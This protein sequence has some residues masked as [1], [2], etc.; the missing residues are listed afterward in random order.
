MAN[1]IQILVKINDLGRKD[2][3]HFKKFMYNS[4]PM[5]HMNQANEQ[6]VDIVSRDIN[7]D[8]IVDYCAT[9]ETDITTIYYDIAMG[10]AHKIEVKYGIVASIKSM[11]F[12]MDAECAIFEDSKDKEDGFFELLKDT[13]DN[14]CVDD[15][16]VIKVGDSIWINTLLCNDCDLVEWYFENQSRELKV[17]HIDYKSANLYVDGCEYGININEVAKARI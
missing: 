11:T 10:Y 9:N 7:M 6:R 1:A 4:I 12:G 16:N 15:E 2:I 3:N 5:I 13:I 8:D 14:V 17:N